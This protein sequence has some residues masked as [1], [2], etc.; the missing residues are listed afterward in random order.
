MAKKMKKPH[1]IIAGAREALAI[2]KGKKMPA[3][4]TRLAYMLWSP[5]YGIFGLPR[6]TKEAAS[7]MRLHKNERV[8]K[9]RITTVQ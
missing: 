5:I 1:K 6:D 2:A 7:T 9:V 3:R 4:A 8:V